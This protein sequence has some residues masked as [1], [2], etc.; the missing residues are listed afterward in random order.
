MKK[1]QKFMYAP[2]SALLIM[3]IA[4]LLFGC[5]H[6]SSK[7]NRIQTIGIREGD[8][9]VVLFFK[10]NPYLHFSPGGE[11]EICKCISKAFKKLKTKVEIVPSDV[12]RQI[13][14]SDVHEENSQST[15]TA[16]DR[17]LRNRNNLEQIKGLGV[18]YIVLFSGRTEKY[19]DPFK[20]GWYSEW[21]N[22]GYLGKRVHKTYIEGK[23]YDIERK[24]PSGNINVNSQDTSYF[25]WANLVLFYYWPAQSE[26]PKVCKEFGEAVAKFI[27]GEEIE[28]KIW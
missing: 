22:V 23:I 3:V 6:G 16:I 15:E 26:E 5:A 4:L 11:Q 14:F 28:E 1:Y 21:Q 8:K 19:M 2:L 12:F 27:I 20:S 13:A 18:R 17:M 24:F 10:T 9:I 25:G 7:V